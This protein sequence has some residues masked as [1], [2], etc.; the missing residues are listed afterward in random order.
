MLNDI[1]LKAIMFGVVF[2]VYSVCR[3]A[4]CRIFVVVLVALNAECCDAECRGAP[5]SISLG[6]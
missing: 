4:E 6:I 3:Y 1:I 5:D 2:C